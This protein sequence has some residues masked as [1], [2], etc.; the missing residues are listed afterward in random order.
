[1]GLG[2]QH[3]GTIAA[4]AYLADMTTP[5]AGGTA[6]TGQG[7]G[8][9]NW[10]SQAHCCVAGAYLLFRGGC[11][12][13]GGRRCAASTVVALLLVPHLADMN[14][15]CH[16]EE[17]S[18]LV[19]KL[20]RVRQRQVAAAGP[21]QLSGVQGFKEAFLL[22]NNTILSTPVVAGSKMK[23]ELM[24]AAD[25]A[26]PGLDKPFELVGVM[27]GKEGR[28]EQVRAEVERSGGGGWDFT[29]AG[30]GHSGLS[31]GCWA[32]AAGPSGEGLWPGA[33]RR[34]NLK[35]TVQEMSLAALM[36]V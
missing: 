12:E 18:M 10:Q 14:P 35:I 26:S 17:A 2:S 20:A 19:L 24:T 5:V 15:L 3:G 9:A 21:E 28:A 4:G 22:E 23:Q 30:R 25:F 29:G 32:G 16:H 36:V 13:P 11:A 33:L 1:M 31:Q 34:E 8:S 6:A 7:S 27:L